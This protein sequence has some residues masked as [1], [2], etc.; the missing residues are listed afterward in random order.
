MN[1]LE[2]LA[3]KLLQARKYR[4]LH[5]PPET[6]RDLIEQESQ[7]YHDPKEIEESVRKKLHQLT[8]LYLGD[9]DYEAALHEVSQLNTRTELEDF[10]RRILTCH[11]STRERLPTLH[12]FYQR[13][14][15]ITGKPRHILDLACG[16][17]PFAL[18]LIDM[19]L[20]IDY[21][22]YDI[23]LPRV[24]LLNAYFKQCEFQAARAEQRDILVNPPTQPADVAFFFKE[25]HRMEQ[26][27]KG[28][29]R[30]LWEALRVEY[31]LVSLPSID[32]GKTHDMR[33]R[34]RNLVRETVQG[35]F[36]EIEEVEF[37]DEMVF[38]IHKGEQE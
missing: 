30:L 2:T 1:S 37:E 8:A 4:D 19:L 36:W 17:N 3:Q 7:R 6:I 21:Q 27:R 16:L 12:D 10:A 13:L 26:R 31:L 14:F 5:L 24:N 11:T 32:I 20:D 38:C 23:H 33:E 22:A 34:M 28:S 18:P 25:A 29:N 9:P 35:Y 15:A